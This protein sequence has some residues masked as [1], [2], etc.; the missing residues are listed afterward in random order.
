M[1]K[2]KKNINEKKI[3]FFQFFCGKPIA[4]LFERPHQI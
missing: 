4:T 3:T 2:N 1:E